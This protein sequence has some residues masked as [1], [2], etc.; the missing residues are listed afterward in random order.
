MTALAR[1]FTVRCRNSNRHSWNIGEQVEERVAHDARHD[2]VRALVDVAQNERQ[3]EE[4]HG[5]G[6]VAEV[7]EAK[8]QRADEDRQPAVGQPANA[9]R[10]GCVGGSRSASGSTMASD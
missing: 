6:A 10:G 7:G 2:A 9:A 1:R 3:D 4:R 8:E 5:L